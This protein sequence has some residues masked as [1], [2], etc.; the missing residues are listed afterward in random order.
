MKQIIANGPSIWEDVPPQFV[1]FDGEDHIT[2]IVEDRYANIRPS[3]VVR[4]L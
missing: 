1:G 3:I 4:S 2:K